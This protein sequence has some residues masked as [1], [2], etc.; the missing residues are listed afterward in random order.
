MTTDPTLYKTIWKP[1]P[2]QELFIT[3]PIFDVMFGGARGGGKTDALLGDFA[4]HGQT[5]GRLAKG[6][7]FRKTMPEFEEVI[8]R[9]KEIYNKIGARFLQQ[10]STWIFPNG[11]T[12]KLR[13]LK[14]ESDAE[15]YQGHSY[16][17]VGVD[18]IG[19]FA[20]PDPID[21]LRAT[22]RSGSGV[23]TFFRA[24]CNPGG[25]GHN[26]IKQRY[27][28]QSPPMIPYYSDEIQDYRVFIPSK[29]QD[30]LALVNNDPNYQKRVKSAAGEAEWLAK[31]WLD[32]DWDIVAGGMFDDLWKRDIH[33]IR[34]FKI[35]HTWYIDRSFDWGSSA[36][37]SVGWWAESNGDPAISVEGK[38]LYFPKGTLIRI[39]E[40]Y[41]WNGTP[42]KGIRMADSA[43]AEGIISREKKMGIHSRVKPGPAD[44]AIFGTATEEQ[45]A[46][47]G[48]QWT[49]SDK[50][51]VGRAAGWLL[52]RSYMHNSRYSPREK[53]GMY[54]FG[55]CM[56]FIR[57]VPSL[58]RDSSNLDDVD[59]TT[60]DHIG[61]E[62]RYRC[63]TKKARGFVEKAT[64]SY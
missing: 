46:M 61:D 58:L 34:P 54:V 57:T 19:N 25:R 51:T 44:S 17:W 40:W 56:Q 29:L 8:S 16:T 26:W 21:L 22:L 53:P 47:M 20:S 31:A 7:L 4:V 59:T 35:P 42:N 41:G 9:S 14:K 36:P 62:V 5:Y 15:N 60:E 18:E 3:C 13:Y 24:S 32:G 6:I 11:A 2:K 50:Q 28:D 10:K 12:L 64:G 48:V 45:M 63:S 30:N 49:K 1:Q 27:I 38:K 37:F 39:G 55:N 23:P 52:M 33:V 43:I